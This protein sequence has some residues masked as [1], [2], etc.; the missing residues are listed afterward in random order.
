MEN[1]VLSA[2]KQHAPRAWSWRLRSP[3]ALCDKI[4]FF[5]YQECLQ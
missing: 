2:C 3:L 5:F 4:V 1:M